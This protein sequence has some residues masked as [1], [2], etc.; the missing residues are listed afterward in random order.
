MDEVAPLQT[1]NLLDAVEAT[2]DAVVRGRFRV[3]PILRANQAADV[4]AIALE[5]QAITSGLRV[6]RPIPRSFLSN[7][8]TDAS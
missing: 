1:D 6:L 4:S 8:R 5:S 7:G 3:V 2:L